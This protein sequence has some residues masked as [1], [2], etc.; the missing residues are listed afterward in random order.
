MPRPL[1]YCAIPIFLF[2]AGCSLI[3]SSWRIFGS[4]LDKSQRAQA[5]LDHTQEETVQ[6][7]QAA[8]HKAELALLQAP[9]GDRPTA[10]GRD[11][12]TEA[13]ALLDQAKGPPSIEDEKAWRNLVAGLLSQNEAVRAAAEKQRAV[14]TANTLDLAHRL[15]A[16][17]A[18]AERANERALGYARESE[19]LADFARKLKLGFFSIVGLLVLGTVLS[20][21]SRFFP[22]LGLASRVV[23]GVVA[24]GITFVAH[25]AEAGLQRV[26]QG[27]AKLRGLSDNAEVL[28]ERAFDGVTDA[29]HQKLIAAGATA[30]QTPPAK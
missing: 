27:M 22:A 5:K 3:P 24:P 19:G 11:Y 10:V 15:S 25:R 29:D 9:A 28:I 6:R 14:D 7:A 8:V 12:V 2:L 20:F 18:A 23:N 13:R 30:A 1:R 21:A 16:A 17:T 4:P 26:G